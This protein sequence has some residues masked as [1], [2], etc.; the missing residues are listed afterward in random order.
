[1][2]SSR[3]TQPPTRSFA[4][5]GLPGDMVTVAC[6]AGT[7]AVISTAPASPSLASAARAES[8]AAASHATS[9]SGFAAAR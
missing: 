5:Y 9:Q 8:S 3:R 4:S 7:W 1:M 6:S 2:A